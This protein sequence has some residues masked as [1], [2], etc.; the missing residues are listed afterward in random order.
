MAQHR[1]AKAAEELWGKLE[2]VFEDRVDRALHTFSVPT[3]KDI[4]TLS[5]RVAELT[6][7]TKKISQA[8]QE[9]RHPRA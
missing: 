2:K 5:H 9:T 8:A 7:V 3:K 6:A 1:A 4:D